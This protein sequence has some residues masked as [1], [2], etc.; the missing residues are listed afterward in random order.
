MTEGTR[1]IIDDLKATSP[2]RIID[3]IRDRAAHNDHIARVNR[4]R[5]AVRARNGETHLLARN[6]EIVEEQRLPATRGPEDDI[7]R[8]R[9]TV[10]SAEI[11]GEEPLPEITEA[12]RTSFRET[13]AR[14]NDHVH[15]PIVVRGRTDLGIIDEAAFESR[16]PPHATGGPVGAS[17]IEG[18]LRNVSMAV[19]DGRPIEAVELPILEERQPVRS[20]D[21]E[22]ISRVVR[23]MTVGQLVQE[24]EIR[25]PCNREELLTVA[26]SLRNIGWATLNELEVVLGAYSELRSQGFGHESAYGGVVSLI[27]GRA[28]LH[29]GRAGAS[30]RM[31]IQQLS[32]EQQTR[33]AEN[34]VQEKVVQ[35]KL[36]DIRLIRVD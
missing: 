33:K 6:G 15:P 3:I 14:I 7:Q 10:W 8:A 35:V 25:Y 24:Y 16:T 4:N 18:R 31:A 17:I 2:M 30:L 29:A 19:R 9:E 28:G 27:H 34:L 23:T 32:R 36:P 13:L 20:G 1:Q 12:D 11:H 22:E 26:L 5:R 21:A